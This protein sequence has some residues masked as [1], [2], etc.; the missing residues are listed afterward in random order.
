MTIERFEILGSPVN[1]VNM[2]KA[3]AIAEQMI[4]H[5]Q[6]A[7]S[8]LAVNPEK[9]I[10]AQKNPQIAAA[11]HAA[12]LCIPDGIG[13]VLAA[14][15][16]GIKH[17]SR[18]PGSELMPKLCEL[19]AAKG[20]SIYL[21]G[22]QESVNAKTAET[23]LK[24]YPGLKIAGRDN[25]YL[26]EQEQPALVE[27]INRSGAQIIFVALG[28]PRQECWIEA[29]KQKLQHVRI[30][31]GVGG[32]FDVITGDIKRAPL[33]F[34]RLNLEWAYRLITQPSRI[35]RQKALPLFIYRFLWSLRTQPRG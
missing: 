2:D 20:Y 25:G 34:R 5:G 6:T 19:A 13:V 1:C 33:L 16:M 28:S 3:V 23:L 11:L 22:G 27:R 29:N 26:S 10:T 4:L 17:I 15:V 8:I 35:R 12:A 9:V 21:F 24:Q 7:N 30:C 14:R 31:Q 18:V 32:T